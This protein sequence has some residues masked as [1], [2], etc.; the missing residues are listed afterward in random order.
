MTL[1]GYDSFEGP[2]CY[3]GTSLLKNRLGT[4][5][6]SVL[7]AF[8]LEITTL[9][10][11]EPLPA[12]K[13]GPAH[14]RAVHRHLFQDVYSWA[15]RYRTVRTAK[16]GNWFCFPEHIPQQMDHVFGSL[17]AENF[18]ADRTFD[19]FV[20]GAAVFLAELNAIHPFREGNGRAQLALMHIVSI[21]AGHPLSFALVKANPFLNA[22][23]A[24]FAGDLVPLVRELTRLRKQ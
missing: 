21:Q 17:R 7:E 2:Y 18:L 5:D 15:G 13:L 23:V 20:H 24:S 6:A 3:K 22:M 16:G 11:D 9:R 19:A 14:Y 4:R 1:G 8:E 12:G 10:A